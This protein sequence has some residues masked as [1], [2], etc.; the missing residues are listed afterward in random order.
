MLLQEDVRFK[1]L[2]YGLDIPN[3][4]YKGLQGFPL[5]LKVIHSRLL[6]SFGFDWFLCVR[7]V[8]WPVF[9]GLTKD[10]RSCFEGLKLE[11]EILKV[12]LNF[13]RQCSWASGSSS[14]EN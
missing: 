1:E 2:K 13:I 12:Y 6:I 14:K 3:S 7:K 9:I 5:F 11:D 10:S 4:G 8:L